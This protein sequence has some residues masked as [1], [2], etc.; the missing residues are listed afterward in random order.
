M[1]IK[2][3]ICNECEKESYIFSKGRCKNCANIEYRRKAIENQ[4]AKERNPSKA[5]PYKAIRRKSAQ[6]MK[7]TQADIKFFKEIWN[8]RPHYCE[9][10][11]AFLGDEFNPVFFSHILTKASHPK[12]RLLKENILLMSY[13]IHTEWEFNSRSTP[14]FKHRFKRALYIHDKLKNKYYD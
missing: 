2:L 12:F 10:T 11:G 6:G 1:K 5:K 3:K 9:I 4:R 14:M 13:K 7:Q 8:E